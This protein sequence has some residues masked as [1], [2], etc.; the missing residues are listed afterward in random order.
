M[1]TIESWVCVTCR[2]SVSTLHCPDC[3]E[4]VLDKRDLGLRH[5]VVDAFHSLTDVDGRLLRSFRGLLLRPGTLTAAYLEG[6]RKRYLS[7]FQ[8]FLIANV[9]FFAVQSFAPDK[10]FSSSLQSHLHGQDWSELAGHLVARHLDARQLTLAA[11]APVFDQAVAVN[12]RSFV[13]VMVL[14]FALVLLA[15]FARDRRP[16]AA[17]VVF[18]LHFYAFQLVLLCAL[19]ALLIV[20]T[21][22]GSSGIPSG[23]L[24][25][26]L[27]ALQLGVSGVY[28]YFAAGTAYGLQGVRRVAS[29]VALVFAAACVVL[30]YRF[31]V[32]LVTLYAT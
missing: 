11:Y 1:A 5:L 25:K 32:F 24:D 31:F 27:F 28:L 4:R 2:T 3:G 12:A 30:G 15:L 13:F 8:I 23:P 20:S 18:S 22:F 7:P 21:W 26:A 9:L 6:P 17:H 19:L 29:T 14:P 10:V 16:F